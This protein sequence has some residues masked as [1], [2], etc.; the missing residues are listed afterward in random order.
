MVIHPQ[1]G[2]SLFNIY[3]ILYY[4]IIIYILY[5]YIY[6][7]LYILIAHSGCSQPRRSM[8]NSIGS[9]GQH[10]IIVHYIYKYIYI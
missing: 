9:G 2:V 10:G 7:L 8:L 1:L 3:I 4:I 5:Y 6:I